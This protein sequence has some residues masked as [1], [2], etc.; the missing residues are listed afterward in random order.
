MSKKKD[1]NLLGGIGE[2]N[3]NGGTQYHEKDR[4]YD[5]DGVAIT[6]H[7]NPSFAPNYIENGD[8]LTLFMSKEFGGDKVLK[9]QSSTIKAQKVDCGVAICDKG[10]TD[11]SKLRIRKLTPEECM[12]LMG[13]TLDDVRQMRKAGMKDMQIYHCAGD[14]IVSNCIIALVGTMLGLT[15]QQL[16]EKLE[17]Y[18]EQILERNDTNRTNQ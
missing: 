12:T 17:N 13:F 1:I 7:T 5:S 18:V 11:M 10:E 9:Q 14:S 16:T 15:D 3:A 6:I 8:G 2:K 4:V